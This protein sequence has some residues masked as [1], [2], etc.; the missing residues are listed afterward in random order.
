MART[1]YGLE[2]RVLVGVSVVRRALERRQR[3]IGA[4]L[5]LMS[6]LIAVV[7]LLLFVLV[8]VLVRILVRVLA[9]KMCVDEPMG[10]RERGGR[11]APEQGDHEGEQPER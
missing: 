1:R 2:R 9:Q 5:R 4:R 10:E 11:E 8:L 7:P 3:S 6:V